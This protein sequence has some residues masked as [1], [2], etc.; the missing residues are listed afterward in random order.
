MYPL[1]LGQQ[2]VGTIVRATVG[3]SHILELFV[4]IALVILTSLCWLIIRCCRCWFGTRDYTTIRLPS[5]FDISY[6][7]PNTR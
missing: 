3:A 5:G 4:A 1:A 6:H 2:Q 7:G